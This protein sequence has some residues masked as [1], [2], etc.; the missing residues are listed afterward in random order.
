[1]AANGT[2]DLNIL[3][4]RRLRPFTVDTHGH[5]HRLHV[6]FRGSYEFDVQ[7]RGD[8]VVLQGN[9]NAGDPREPCVR[10]SSWLT[11]V[12]GR[13][14]NDFHSVPVSPGRELSSPTFVS[15]RAILWTERT[16]HAL[17]PRIRAVPDTRQLPLTRA[18]RPRCVART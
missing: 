11:D 9:I 6:D 3:G 13:V 14:G 12:A 17:P 15:P 10:T 8:R 18:E 4:G 1:L 7:R 5:T 2:V 16:E